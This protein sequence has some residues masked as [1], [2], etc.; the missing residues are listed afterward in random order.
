M[1]PER[2]A[3]Y[4]YHAALMEPWDGPAAVCFTDGR[5]IGA[6]LDRNGLRPAR[7]CVT[8]D[9]LICLASE[10]GVLPF[11]EE[12][13]VRKW[14]LQPG[15]MLL[16]DLEQ[17]RI[18]EDE[19]LK[20]QLAGAQPYAEWLEAAQYKLE[21]LDHIEPELSAGAASR[22]PTC[23]SASRRSATRRRTSPSFLE[24]MA[25]AGDDPIGSMGTDT[26]LAVLSEP[27]APAVRLFQ[28]ELRAGHQP[29]DRPDPR[30]AGDEPDQHGRPAAQP[31]RPRCRHAQA[32]RGQ[33][34]DPDQRGPRE[35][36][37]GRGGARR[38]VPLRDDRHLLGCQRR[39]R[40][41]RAGAARRCAGRR[42]RRCCRTTT[43]SCCRDRA[44][45]PERMP[46]PALLAT[47]AVH[48]HLVR[49]GLRMQTGLVVETGE[50]REVHHFCALAGYGA[51]AINPYVAFETLEDIRAARAAAL[52]RSR[53]A[54]ELR[55]GDRQGHPQGHVQDGHLDLPVVLRGADLRR[56]RAVAARSST[57]TSPAPR[58]PSRASAWPKWPRR[59]CAA[60]RSPTATTRSTSTCSIPAAST[61]SAC[62]ARTMP[63]PRAPSPTS[64]TRCAATARSA[65]R[66]TRARSTSSPSGC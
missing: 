58:P 25:Q 14:R 17:G 23:W 21:D 26:P 11:Q 28:A 57:S 2:R 16:V 52:G 44:Q 33:P 3:F 50:A 43:S 29:A 38:R 12:D 18:I 53:G 41:R 48:H 36:P 30:G 1:D 4:E 10:S 20:A 45:G 63:G 24:P 5:Q 54:Q 19:E 60:T 64:S 13:I 61:S 7:Y 15:K 47:A 8:N 51:E 46:I 22:R 34:A 31:A 27:S 35:D 32:A 56:G 39:G 9:D 6:T 37:L 49:Q 42:P 40:G 59:R 55:Q 62:A 65:T 66:T